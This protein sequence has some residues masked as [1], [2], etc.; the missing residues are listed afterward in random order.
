M[1]KKKR[2][3]KKKK[4]RKSPCLNVYEKQPPS[5][6]EVSTYFK[7]CSGALLIGFHKFFE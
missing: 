5:Y 7:V 6:Q 4:R 3:K 1:E 2:K